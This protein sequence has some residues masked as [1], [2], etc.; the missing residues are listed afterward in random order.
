MKSIWKFPIEAVGI[1][2]IPMPLGAKLLDVQI[3]A[4]QPCLWA[5]V[6]PAAEK[7]TRQIS[8]YGT[9]HPMLLPDQ[10]YIASFQ[11]AGGALVFHA[12]DGGER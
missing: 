7:V 12:F 9:G 10:P 5:L 11:L 3:Q 2:G 4:G 1:Q 8:V 6:D